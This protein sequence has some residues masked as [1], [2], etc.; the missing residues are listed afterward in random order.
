MLYYNFNLKQSIFSII[1]THIEMETDQY[2]KGEYLSITYIPLLDSFHIRVA[3][4]ILSKE[5]PYTFYDFI[6][7]AFMQMAIGSANNPSITV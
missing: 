4:S 1:F 6:P 5:S 3:N 2:N 7:G